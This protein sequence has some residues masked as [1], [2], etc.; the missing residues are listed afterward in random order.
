MSLSV[1]VTP[2]CC[3]GCESSTHVLI[4]DPDGV[5]EL[6]LERVRL[7]RIMAAWSAG[8]GSVFVGEPF[9]RDLGQ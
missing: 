5:E 7:G 6:D 1:V 4:E 9:I 2:G 3:C 8:H